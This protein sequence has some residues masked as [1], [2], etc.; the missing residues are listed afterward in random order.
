MEEG[1]NIC[2]FFLKREGDVNDEIERLGKFVLQLLIEEKV[3]RKI[4]ELVIR[5]GVDINF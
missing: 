3:D 5:F 1:R 4:I 2:E